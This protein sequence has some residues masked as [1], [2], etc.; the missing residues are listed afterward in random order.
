[1]ES[2]KSTITILGLTGSGKSAL[3]NTLTCK[4]NYFIERYKP[5]SQTQEVIGTDCLFNN[6]KVYIIDIPGLYNVNNKDNAHL[7]QITNFF[8]GKPDLKSFFI[9]ID[10]RPVRIDSTIVRF[11][12][13][14]QNMYPEKKFYNH[15]CVIWTFC[16]ENQNN[17]EQKK[18]GLKK[19]QFRIFLKLQIK[20]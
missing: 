7:E 9:T 18:E 17:I 15:I 2:N 16:K 12:Q 8:R 19:M 11:F 20:N 3:G 5:E 6:R 1:M 10:F 14:L 13:I 4:E